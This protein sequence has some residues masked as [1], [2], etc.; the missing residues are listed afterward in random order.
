MQ[1]EISSYEVCKI[2]K[3]AIQVPIG[4]FLL[5]FLQSSSMTGDLLRTY[6]LQRSILRRPRECSSKNFF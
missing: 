1:Q 3:F 2:A 5:S 4:G 6:I